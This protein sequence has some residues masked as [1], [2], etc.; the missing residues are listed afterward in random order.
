MI[1]IKQQTNFWHLDHEDEEPVYAIG[2]LINGEYKVFITDSQATSNEARLLTREDAR[3]E[4]GHYNFTKEHYNESLDFIDDE[5]RD[6]LRAE[7]KIIW[8]K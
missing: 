2:F 8:K 6:L 7:I 3:K 4:Y 1:E 5:I